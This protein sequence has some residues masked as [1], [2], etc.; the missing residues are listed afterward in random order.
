MPTVYKEEH[1]KLVKCYIENFGLLHAQEYD[2]KKGLNCCISDNGTGKT[3]LA[4]FI[5]AM[6][7]GIG[8]TRKVLLDENPRKKY[9]PWQGGRFGGSLT[10]EVG[11]KRYT[12]ERS[13]GVR[14]AD[15]T[16]RLVNADSGKE[17][18]D[19]SENLGEELFGIDRDGFLR[20]VYLSEKNLKG[21]NENK[22]ISAKLSD[23]VGV[24]G[25]VGGFDDAI[26]L[27]EDRRK[28][29]YKKGN[30]GEIA[31]VK[32]RIAECD[33][34][35]DGILRLKA[36]ML[37]K[38]RQL[39]E[40]NSELQ[41]LST[42]EAKEREKLVN[43]SKQHEKLSHEERYSAMLVSLKAEKEK[44]ARSKEF[45]RSGVPS[46]TEIDRARDAY[47]ESERLKGEAYGKDDNDELAKLRR[48]F[49]RGT[50]FVEI[51]EMEQEAIL[52]SKKESELDRIKQEKDPVSVEMKSIFKDRVPKM[53]E[54]KNLAK[55]KKSPIPYLLISS[56]GIIGVILGITIGASAKIPITAASAVITIIAF[57]SAFIPKKNKQLLSFLKEF[58]LDNSK[59]PERELENIRNDIRRYE[60]LSAERQAT[61]DALCE[62]IDNSKRRIFPFLKKF[63][64]TDAKD[65]IDAV[66]K[67]KISYSRFFSMNEAD[68]AREEAK[69]NKA[70]KSDSLYREAMSF[71]AK[72]QT[73]TE[74]PFDEIRAKLNEYNYLSVTVQRMESECDAYS[75]RYGVSGNAAPIGKET[76]IAINNSLS[77]ISAKRE[78]IG[79][80]HA[81]L[82]REI[83]LAADETDK[84]D[85]I[86][87]S[88]EELEELLKKHT[89]SLEVIKKTSL[90][91]KEACDN[92][93]AKYLGKTKAKFEEYSRI[94][95]GIDGEYS[96]STDF[97]ISKNEKGASRSV[98]S[99]SRGVRDLYALA[100]RFAL[101][102]ALYDKDSPF[103]ILDDPLIAL[104]DT[105]LEG[106]KKLLKSMGREKQILYFTCAKSRIIE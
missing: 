65:I 46:S 97:E 101:I 37:D 56:L 67:I 14:A 2:F 69:L 72:Y 98:E 63:P 85:E 52:L 36:E 93:T 35:L 75:V 18:F 34:R 8:D 21:K 26:K 4:S 31:N 12:V 71:L 87:S 86:I 62:S 96:I 25:D 58:E 64:V 103:I 102:D 91:L 33:R 27:L 78:E 1:M 22:S 100:I 32:E 94:I 9:N 41:R 106:A 51:G 105:R 28:F 60:A 6:F 20:T 99:Y 5:E 92:I 74:T 29:Y 73:S 50:N 3:T 19:Y 55:T 7:F 13:F 43:I 70:T 68:A 24:D 61:T 42:L 44:L 15:D 16:Y 88:K 66:T 79:R 39:H 80:Q 59:D 95:A 45:F 48:F 53:D 81:V 30:T 76:E 82:E 11:K 49:Q 90:L 77:E 57:V 89:E 17:C 23:L 83:R 40:Y 84:R 38:E 54:V 47:L 104:D 10:F